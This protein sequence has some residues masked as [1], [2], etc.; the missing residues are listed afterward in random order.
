MFFSATTFGVM[1]AH[2]KFSRMGQGLGDMASAQ[3]EPI[4]GS[5]GRSP[6]WVQ[7]Q[8]P[9]SRDQGAKL[10][11]EAFVRLKKGP[12]LCCQYGKTF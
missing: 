11:L 12:K 4:M 3:R 1:G 10:C 5:G 9:R 2:R 8:S 7:R 6:Q